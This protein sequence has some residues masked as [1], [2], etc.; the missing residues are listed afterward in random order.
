MH[1]EKKKK[2]NGSYVSFLTPAPKVSAF[3][4]FCRTSVVE[5]LLSQLKFL[6]CSEQKRSFHNGLFNKD[7]APVAAHII[8]WGC[9]IILSIDYLHAYHPNS[10]LMFSAFQFPKFPP[11]FQ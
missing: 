3:Q 10:S 11:I 9:C 8:L 1:E 7:Q 6:S 2:E 4:L 5:E